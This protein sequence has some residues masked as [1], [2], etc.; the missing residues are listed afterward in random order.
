VGVAKTCHSHPGKKVDVP[1]SINVLY[2]AALSTIED[3][4]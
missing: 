4:F 3:D 2:N 1:I